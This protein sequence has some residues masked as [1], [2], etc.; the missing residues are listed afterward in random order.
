MEDERG[1]MNYYS[2]PPRV[3]IHSKALLLQYQ[4]K[5]QFLELDAETVMFGRKR[6][7][8]REFSIQSSSSLSELSSASVNG[9]S[10]DKSSTDKASKNPVEDVGEYAAEEVGEHPAAEVGGYPD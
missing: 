4:K 10:L 7:K 6:K 8:S 5:G 9:S 1:R 3:K 2:P